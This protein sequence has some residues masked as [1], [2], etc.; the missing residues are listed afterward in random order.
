MRAG[1]TAAVRELAEGYELYSIN[2]VL[3]EVGQLWAFRYPEHNPLL[4][5]EKSGESTE[6]VERDSH[7]TLRMQAE[8]HDGQRPARGK[9][10]RMTRTSLWSAVAHPGLARPPCGGFTPPAPTS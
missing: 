8:R 7:G 3:G 1:I 6:L 5:L 2:F 9:G 4:I 10:V